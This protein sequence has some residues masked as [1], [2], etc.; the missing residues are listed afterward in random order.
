MLGFRLIVPNRRVNFVT[1]PY[2]LGNRIIP[3]GSV[4]SL[5]AEL[6]YSPVM[7][8]TPSET[9]GNA[10]FGDLF[11]STNL[12]FELVEGR[13]A[14]TIRTVLYGDSLSPVK[15][16]GLKLLRTLVLPQYG[17]KIE[18]PNKKSYFE[19]K[20]KVATDLLPFRKILISAFDFVRHE[21]DVSWLKPAPPIA[22]RITELKQ[23]FTP[24]TVGIHFRGTDYR[25]THGIIPPVEN[26][27]TRMHAEIELDPNVR[28]FFAS[29]G[30]KRDKMIVD[31]FKERLIT[32]KK[33]S[34]RMTLHGQCDAVVDL[35]GL[36]A[37][38]RIIG[39]GYSS[40]VTLAAL[41][42]DKP[43]LRIVPIRKKR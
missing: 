32:F 31:L 7:I 23:Q 8:W 10:S 2:G 20:N 22:S 6:N 37:T 29:D 33:S 25:S 12:P 11:D 13:E 5:A 15:R 41:I 14:R 9:I 38:S 26:M 18:L 3:M 21:S 16:K 43:L 27:I 35:F 40:F 39:F 24:N 28:F 36:A 42:G 34:Y 30:D 1:P 4:L 19:F 17:K